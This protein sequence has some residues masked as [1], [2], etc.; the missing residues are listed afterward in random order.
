MGGTVKKW[1][2]HCMEALSAP[3]ALN[4]TL[5]FRFLCGKPIDGRR[6]GRRYELCA[7]CST[8]FAPELASCLRENPIVSMDCEPSPYRIA[9]KDRYVTALAGSLHV[10]ALL[11][12]IVEA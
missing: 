5:P 1:A 8:L 6:A 7:A 12:D 4:L 2:R 3:Q 9:G 11:R 10:H